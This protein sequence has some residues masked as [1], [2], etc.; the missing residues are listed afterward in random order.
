MGSVG[1]RAA[2]LAGGAF[3][4]LSARDR[5]GEFGVDHIISGVAI[6]ILAPGVARFLSCEVFNNPTQSP[7]VAGVGQFTVPFFAGGGLFGSDT[8]DCL[9]SL[10]DREIFFCLDIAGFLARPRSA[11]CRCS[12]CWPC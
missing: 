9:G 8:P 11:D 4:G 5:H 2:R 7:D 6:N 1:G 10:D 12:R 3:G